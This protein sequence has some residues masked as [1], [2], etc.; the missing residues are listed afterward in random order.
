MKRP[1]LWAVLLLVGLLLYAVVLVGSLP[2]QDPAVETQR[3]PNST[4]EPLEHADATIHYENLSPSAQ[5]WFDDVPQSDNQ[6]ETTVTPIKKLPEPWLSI[7]PPGSEATAP[8][9]TEAE[10]Q[11]RHTK[12]QR[13]V[14]VERD[15]RYHSIVLIRISPRPPLQA[16]LLRLGAIIGAIG[17]FGFGCQRWLTRTL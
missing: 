13:I 5:R 15:G 10:V 3:D 16:V 17:A 6:Y 14:Q 9:T 7:A 1:S 12:I 8:P 4:A 11:R 2:A